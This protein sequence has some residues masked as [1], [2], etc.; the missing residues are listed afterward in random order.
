MSNI[1]ASTA[2]KKAESRR[3]Y[4]ARDFDYEALALEL[5]NIE[6]GLSKRFERLCRL[7]LE[8]VPERA[9]S[10][11]MNGSNKPLIGEAK[12]IK[13]IHKELIDERS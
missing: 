2:G 10:S 5:E 9:F 12:A 4:V 6:A 3:R 8:Q 11:I 7:A 13:K 1:E